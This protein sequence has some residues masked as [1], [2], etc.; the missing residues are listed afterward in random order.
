MQRTDPAA[1]ALV[2]RVER[3]QRA[4]RQVV[5][6]VGVRPG[7]G[8]VDVR[9]F[10]RQ[11]FADE[12]AHVGLLAAFSVVV[13]LGEGGLAEARY[14]QILFFRVPGEA[15]AG[16]A[17]F[18]DA[19]G[20]AGGGWGWFRVGGEGCLAGYWRYGR[21]AFVEEVAEAAG[22]GWFAQAGEITESGRYALDN[23]GARAGVA[24]RRL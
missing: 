14:G 2:L 11:R 6:H 7:L 8:L 1:A 19:E 9:V 18:E 13:A 10:V 4:S 22:Y 5:R 3:A 17:L 21:A 16:M 20:T 23:A 15:D 24:C 12:R